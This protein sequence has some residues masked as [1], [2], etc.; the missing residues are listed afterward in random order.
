MPNAVMIAVARFIELKLNLHIDNQ[1]TE[2]EVV[3][4]LAND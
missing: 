3:M 4:E 1:S 2:S